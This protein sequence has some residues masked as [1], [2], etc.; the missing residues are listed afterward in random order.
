[1]VVDVS[2]AAGKPV[3]QGRGV[4]IG[5]GGAPR[6]YG[7]EKRQF[8]ALGFFRARRKASVLKNLA[9]ALRTEAVRC[10]LSVG[11]ESKRKLRLNTCLSL[12]NLLLSETTKVLRAVRW[13]SALSL[14][15]LDQTG[16]A[17]VIFWTHC[18]LWP[19]PFAQA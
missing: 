4:V 15:W 3:S 1:M 11:L 14:C 13:S 16:L 12:C 19:S 18:A 7:L 10:K 9:G 6:R 8:W 5:P 17:K 2:D